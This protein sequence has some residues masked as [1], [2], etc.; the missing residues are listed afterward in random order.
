MPL[1]SFCSHHLH[2]SFF[3]FAFPVPLP[4]PSSFFSSLHPLPFVLICKGW[5]CAGAQTGFRNLHVTFAQ[6]R[7][8]A[9]VYRSYFSTR[10]AEASTTSPSFPK[11]VTGSAFSLHPVLTQ[12]LASF[13]SNLPFKGTLSRI[14]SYPTDAASL[15]PVFFQRGSGYFIFAS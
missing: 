7:R 11:D 8:G 10:A 12:T 3:S 15:I 13:E 1:S 5:Q 6:G 14:F 2:T 9:S 4:F